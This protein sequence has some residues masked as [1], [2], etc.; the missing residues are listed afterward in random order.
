M[1]IL[2]LNANL[3]NWL[4]Q[5][6]SSGSSLT[7]TFNY[8]QKIGHLTC[9]IDAHQDDI[10]EYELHRQIKEFTPDL[11]GLTAES[12]TV[13][14]V[15]VT[16]RMLKN[17]FTG[18]P[19]FLQIHSDLEHIDNI[20]SEYPHLDFVLTGNSEQAATR[21]LEYIGCLVQGKRVQSSGP[22]CLTPSGRPATDIFVRN[23]LLLKKEIDEESLELKSYPLHL[24]FDLTTRCNLRCIMCFRQFKP[25]SQSDV[26]FEYWPKLREMLPYS[27]T[28][29]FSA[30]GETLMYPRIEEVLLD[31]QNFPH[32]FKVMTSNGTLLNNPRLFDTVVHSIDRLGISIE[33]ATKK[34]YEEIRRGAKFKEVIK[35][36]NRVMD[37]N[38]KN[39]NRV[40]VI[41]QTIPMKKN[42]RELP[43][44]VDLAYSLGIRHIACQHLNCISGMEEFKAQQGIFDIP[45][46]WNSTLRKVRERAELYGIHLN[47]PDEL[48]ERA[49][50]PKETD[51]TKLINHNTSIDFDKRQFVNPYK[52]CFEPWTYLAIAPGDPPHVTPCCY[53]NLGNPGNYTSYKELWNWEKIR[54]IRRTV[55]S[56][57]PNDWPSECRQCQKKF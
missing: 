34:T 30:S 43:L 55:N 24:C 39:D 26:P 31:L 6:V 46:E 49:V 33:G 35:N 2:L 15:M 57:N 4:T 12:W 21:L 17:N 25:H 13:P 10:P 16:A 1:R 37:F 7:A 51:L 28:L 23:M 54:N 42:L 3:R 45:T 52:K 44:L 40:E 19:V 50:S 48:N 9:F 8:L 22:T 36:I 11:I 41:F 20:T 47:F 29:V 27:D 38:A 14:Y 5:S 32:I 56:P 18:I 53:I